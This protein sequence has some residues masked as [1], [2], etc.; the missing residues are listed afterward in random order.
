MNRYE[1]KY[2]DKYDPKNAGTIFVFDTLWNK[3]SSDYG[4][5]SNSISCPGEDVGRYID[6]VL[7]I[8]ATYR[9]PAYAYFIEIKRDRFIR[10][11]RK[12][13]RICQKQGL[14]RNQF[15]LIHGD[16]FDYTNNPLY[17]HSLPARI[18]DLGLGFGIHN[19]ICNFGIPRLYRQATYTAGYWK[20]QIISSATRGALAGE[21][22]P[23]YKAY[24]STINAKIESVN[25][26]SPDNPECL[27]REHAKCIEF[28]YQD[29]LY[30]KK[31][32]I[33]NVYEHTVKLKT[34]KRQAKLYMYSY[35]NGSRM[36][37]SLLV[38]K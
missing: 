16:I 32:H 34:N 8:L 3:L 2:C 12:V 25:G 24:L 13:N 33:C 1:K 10:I 35:M 17:K 5:I 36:L 14:D 6:Y 11:K 21:V 19:M 23:R 15:V 7:P 28:L 29:K 20:A 38:Y 31:K 9:Y 18:E 37:A 26:H 27:H 4:M 30:K 22:V